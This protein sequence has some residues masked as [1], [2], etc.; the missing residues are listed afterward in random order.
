MKAAALA[1][2]RIALGFLFVYAA[3]TKLADMGQFAEEVA[4]YQLLPPSLVALVAAVLPGIE[5]LAGTLLIVG[6]VVRPAALVVSVLLAVFVIG[7]SQA[8]L[9][10][11]DLR[12][13]CF[14]GT[15]VATWWTVLRD[16]VMLA[17]ALAI[18]RAGGGRLE[19]AMA[20]AEPH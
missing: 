1:A 18:L 4:N 12:C 20:R 3:A 8:L 13:G 15:D 2:T 16:V 6:A 10:G 14:G 19:G 17:A 9:R 5:I 11:V 7:L